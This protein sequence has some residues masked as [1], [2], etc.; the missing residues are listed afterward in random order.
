MFVQEGGCFGLSFFYTSAPGRGHRGAH[1]G[2]LARQRGGD[3]GH[4]RGAHWR[5]PEGD[6]DVA[7]SAPSPKRETTA[8]CQQ[9]ILFA[10]GVVF[11]AT[12]REGAGGV[13]FELID[14][15]TPE[16]CIDPVSFSQADNDTEDFSHANW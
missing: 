13:V 16:T 9:A 7:K 5:A 12:L 4:P 14:V 10:F 1:A 15:L 2:G 11:K 6:L 3:S 8:G